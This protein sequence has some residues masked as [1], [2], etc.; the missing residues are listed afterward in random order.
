M[1]IHSKLFKFMLPFLAYLLFAFQW[2]YNY[3]RVWYANIPEETIFFTGNKLGLYM[4]YLY[5]FAVTFFIFLILG[6]IYFVKT[7]AS[8]YLNYFLIGDLLI[9]AYYVW[10]HSTFPASWHSNG[11]ISF[12]ILIMFGYSIF[13]LSKIDNPENTNHIIAH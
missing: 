12:F 11:I 2:T 7:P 13:L 10:H 4:I 5:L 9:S 8:K 6:I 3:V 1:F